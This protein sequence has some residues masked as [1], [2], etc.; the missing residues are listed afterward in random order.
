MRRKNTKISISAKF[1]KI[2]AGDLIS[3]NQISTQKILG[4]AGGLNCRFNKKIV[5][6]LPTV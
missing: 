1:P 4:I 3:K 6:A 5:D 2:S